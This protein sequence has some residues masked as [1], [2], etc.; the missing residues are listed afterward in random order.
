MENYIICSKVTPTLP[1]GLV[2]MCRE[3]GRGR[4]STG[5]PSLVFI[6]AIVFYAVINLAGLADLTN[7]ACRA[8]FRINSGG[9]QDKQNHATS[10]RR[11]TFQER[12]Q[13]QNYRKVHYIT[14]K[15]FI[16]IP[17]TSTSTNPRRQI[18]QHREEE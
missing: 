1:V 11:P 8:S 17:G 9:S 15:K 14:K 6:H 4:Q 5:I 7:T 16:N 13:Q 10:V 12:R 3:R 2:A 18:L